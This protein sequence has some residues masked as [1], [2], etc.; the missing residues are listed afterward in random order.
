M[1]P[2]RLHK[3]LDPDGAGTAARLF[4]AAHH[5]LVAIGTG[6]VL[7]DSVPSL[8]QAHGGLLAVLFCLVSAGFAIEYAARC[9]A[10]P[11]APAARHRPPLRVRLAW[12]CSPG[13]IV[14]LLS[15]AA[16]IAGLV[17]GGGDALLLGLVWLCKLVRYAPGLSILGRVVGRAHRALLSL[18]LG[19]GIVLVGASSLAFVFEH[20]AQPQRFGSIPTALW[21]AIVTVTTTGYGD[22]VPKT[23]YG[24]LLAGLIMVGGILVLALLA[25]I[26]A[27]FYADEMRRH[28]FLNTWR[29][30]A[31]L[32]FFQ[33][34]GAPIV[35]DVA[36]LLR[37]RD[38]PAGAVVC[39]RGEPG[40]CMYF[41]ASGTVEIRVNPA[42]LRLG[43]E[44]FFGEIALLTG[45]PRNATVVAVEPCTLLR[46]DIADF[47]ALMAQQPELASI[48]KEEA[49]RRLGPAPA[50]AG[51]RVA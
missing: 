23:P 6:I 27:S 3:M 38:Y 25:A 34:V 37:P 10:A 45:A 44:Q 48:I 13:G 8:R 2:E 49:E 4:R 22:A 15:A 42:P 51:E 16:G 21:W 29:V 41:I 40:D 36:R 50:A 18:L 26:L 17:L 47:H 12:A 30:V 39:R 33:Q 32:P 24:R 35:A 43:S 28:A 7:A 19:F 46:L 14:D 11:A 20:N 9:Y 1:D 5:A 31:G